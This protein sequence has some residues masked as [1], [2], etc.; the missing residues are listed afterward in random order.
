MIPI[1]YIGKKTSFTDTLYGSRATWQ[2]G[3]VVEVDEWQA[4]RLLR[5]P[6]FQDARP[7]KERTAI[8]AERPEDP[9]VETVDLPPLTSLET[10]TKNDLTTFVRRHFGIELD[11]GAKKAELVV[12]AKTLMARVR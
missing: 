5:H 11:A 3:D 6:E 4:L 12:K 2:H 7:R 9:P 8:Q 10:M 1:R